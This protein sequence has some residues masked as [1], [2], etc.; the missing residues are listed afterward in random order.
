MKKLKILLI[1]VCI[2]LV[3]TSY[4]YANTELNIQEYSEIKHKINN[5]LNDSNEYQV[6]NTQGDDVTNAFVD[7]ATSEKATEI[8]DI[9]L[10]LSNNEYS[11][12]RIVEDNIIDVELASKDD[13]SPSSLV[14]RSYSRTYEQTLI[15]SGQV[16]VV[17]YTIYGYLTFDSNNGEITS[18]RSPTIQISFN[19]EAEIRKIQ[20][21][22]GTLSNRNRTI[23]HNI[24]ISVVHMY[25]PNPN[26]DIYVELVMPEINQSYSYTP[27]AH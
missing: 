15:K 6:V 2:L 4:A 23:N 20:V 10:Y 14:G 18:W 17:R 7:Y 25:R 3:N 19:K 11:I 27:M 13:I 8:E 12:L 24:S 16:L 21:S 1:F 5:I 26:S 9:L 22:R